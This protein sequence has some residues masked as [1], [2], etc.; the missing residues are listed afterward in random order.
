VHG[1]RERGEPGI[2][3]A[4]EESS[5]HIV[6]NAAAFGWDIPE[7]VSN[8]LFFLDAYLSPQISQAGAFDLAGILAATEDRAREM[9]WAGATSAGRAC[10]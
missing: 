2:F 1:A 10:S 8:R 5:R 6:A 4:F 9:G 3:V 7:L